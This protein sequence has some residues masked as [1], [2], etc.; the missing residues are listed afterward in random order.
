MSACE[1]HNNEV[2]ATKELLNSQLH[3][4]QDATSAAKKQEIL[5]QFAMEAASRLGKS[6]K[7]TP[8]PN[9]DPLKSDPDKHNFAPFLKNPISTPI[10]NSTKGDALLFGTDI[11]T[12]LRQEAAR[13]TAS[14][15]GGLT[16]D[17][18]FSTVP[19]RDLE[20]TKNSKRRNSRGSKD[21]INTEG[22]Q[23][24]P[25]F[26]SPNSLKIKRNH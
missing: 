22:K 3:K 17:D 11:H 18:G 23:Q 25:G 9:S 1:P 24:F 8:V 2:D 4:L 6:R 14:E 15:P 19:A 7:P 21:N 26:A 20:H 12:K 16:D 13:N 5:Y 10:P